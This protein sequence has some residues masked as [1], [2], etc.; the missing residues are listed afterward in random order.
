MRELH[1]TT[2]PTGAMVMRKTDNKLA[3]FVQCFV[4]PAPGSTRFRVRIRP[5]GS[6]RGLGPNDG[7]KNPAF[8]ADQFFV[9]S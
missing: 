2:T 3:G 9:A 6:D 4:L 1:P 8:Y 5:A 7:Y